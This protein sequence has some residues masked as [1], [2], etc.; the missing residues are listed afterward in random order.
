EMSWAAPMEPA[1]VR[2]AV[3]PYLQATDLAEE[4]PDSES[5]VDNRWLAGRRLALLA[6]DSPE[7]AAAEPEGAV[8]EGAVAEPADAVVEPADGGG[9]ADPR[10]EHLA[11]FLVSPEARLSGV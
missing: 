3:A 11:R 9:E 6:A 8:A 4:L 10:D 1:S 5:L 2:I 7:P